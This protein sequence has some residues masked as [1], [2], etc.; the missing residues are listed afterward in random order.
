MERLNT[1]LLVII[2]GV[3]G[4]SLFRIFKIESTD[5]QAIE[6]LRET[7]KSLATALENNQAA[8]DSAGKIRQTLASFQNKNELLK[9][10]L[11]SIVLVDRLRRPKDWE[12][13][14]SILRN[15]EAN[16]SQLI[17]LRDKNGAFE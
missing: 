8:Q 1:I 3:A 9:V 6:K 14:Q 10:K 2:I 4:I 11:D 15:V 17:I 12:E 16:K 5:K 13:R 7:E